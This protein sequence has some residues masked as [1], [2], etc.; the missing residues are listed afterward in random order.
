MKY[1]DNNSFAENPGNVILSEKKLKVLRPDLFGRRKKKSNFNIEPS[2]EIDYIRE[3]LSCG[4]S[5]PAIVISLNP[6]LIAAYSDDIDCVAV[7][8]FPSYFAKDYSL[9]IRS[10]LITVNTYMRNPPYQ[11]DLIPGPNARAWFGFY[12]L[13]ANF[14]SDST[15]NI[16]NHINRIPEDHWNYIFRLGN[17]YMKRFPNIYRSGSPVYSKIS[18][19]Q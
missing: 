14:L 5:Q 11:K 13:I 2:K 10:K 17:E 19:I 7:L 15:K 4:D 16:Q 12:P 9:Q 8:N 1:H 18:A 6:L 3:H